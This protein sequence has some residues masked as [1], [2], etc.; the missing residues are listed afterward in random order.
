MQEAVVNMIKSKISACFA[1]KEQKTQC[2]I[3]SLKEKNTFVLDF[4]V[5]N[6]TKIE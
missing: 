6:D 4:S 1:G 2:N 5:I 3:C